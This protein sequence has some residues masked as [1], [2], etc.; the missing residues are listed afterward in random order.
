MPLRHPS[1]RRAALASLLVAAACAAPRR[2]P[3]PPYAAALE[4]FAGS[5]LSGPLDLEPALAETPWTLELRL[6]RLDAWPVGG[7]PLGALVRQAIVEPSGDPLRVRG[8]L[9]LGVRVAPPG[10]VPPEASWERRDTGFL[11]PGSALS[12]ESAPDPASREPART[13]WRRLGVLAS[14]PLDPAPGRDALELALVFEGVAAEPRTTTDESEDPRE[15]APPATA[16]RER[17]VLD[18]DADALAQPLVLVLPAPRER[19]P[20]AVLALELRL[21]REAPASADGGSAPESALAL[22][23]SRQAARASLQEAREHARRAAAPLEAGVFRLERSSAL[24]ALARRRPHRSALVFLAD[25]TGAAFAGELAL[26]ADDETLAA[27]QD[28]VRERLASAGPELDRAERLGWFLDGCAYAW[29]ARRLDDPARAPEPELVALLLRQAGELGRHPDLV[30]EALAGCAG[31]A[32]ARARFLAENRIFLEDAS[33]AARVR[34]YDWLRERG[35]APAGYDPLGSREER[36]AALAAAEE[37]E[38][39]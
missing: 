39:G 11:W 3:P 18:V 22:D 14:R 26:V 9:A 12:W 6:A 10:A 19:L 2:A 25:A 17:L 31:A 27:F 36:R 21:A 4:P 33:P 24:D 38:G 28:D 29:L 20:A 37:E 16:R 1:A 15:P 7:T 5:V 35:A 13:P 30:L 32:D 23:A 34:A 8:E